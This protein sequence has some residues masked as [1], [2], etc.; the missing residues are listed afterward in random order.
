ME[1]M[2]NIDAAETYVTKEKMAEV[3]QK[4]KNLE[5]D[6]DSYKMQAD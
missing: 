6:I 1:K 5:S 2:V 4:V 3:K